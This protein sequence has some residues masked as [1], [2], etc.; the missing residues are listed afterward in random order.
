MKRHIFWSGVEAAAG[1]LLSVISAFAIARMI[2]PAELGVGA[3]ATAVHVLLW[4]AVNALF[5]DALVQRATIG[6]TEASS[7]FWASAAMGGLAM[8]VQVGSGWVLAA[9]LHDARLVPM[10]LLLALPLPLVGAGGAMQGVLTRARGYRALAAR[11]IVG[12]G[13]GA[14]IGIALALHDAGAWA[15]VVQL[16]VSSFVGATTL[17]ATAGWRPRMVCCGTAVRALLTV[18]LP[19]TA[20]TLVQLGRYRLFAILIGGTAG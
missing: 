20:S 1:A 13:S 17:L 7:A 16:T 6:D 11:T 3:A 4:V 19:L 18:G 10:A 9:L 5:A 15:P 2:G 8:P 12:Q 14:A